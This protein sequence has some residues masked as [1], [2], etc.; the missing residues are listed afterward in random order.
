MKKSTYFE[1][2][3]RSYGKDNAAVLDVLHWTGSVIDNSWTPF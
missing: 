2:E 1:E 3:K